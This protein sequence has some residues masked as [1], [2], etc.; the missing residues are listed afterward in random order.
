MK[1]QSKKKNSKKKSKDAKA[2]NT[3]DPFFVVIISIIVSIVCL[4]FCVYA[5]LKNE[6]LMKENFSYVLQIFKNFFGFSIFIIYLFIKLLKSSIKAK[7]AIIAGFILN[8]APVYLY[9]INYGWCFVSL[10]LVST[11]L[12]LTLVCLESEDV[13]ESFR[14]DYHSKKYI[15][16]TGL[17][18]LLQ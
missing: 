14:E 18:L 6:V 4:G 2:E 3:V 15:F 16:F 7:A 1:K 8:L 11:A 10:F 13:I 17:L 9:F 5:V 12:F